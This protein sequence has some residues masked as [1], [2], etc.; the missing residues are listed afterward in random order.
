M[1]NSLIAWKIKLPAALC[2]ATYGFAQLCIPIFLHNPVR[3]KQKL[4]ITLPNIE[5][6]RKK[7]KKKHDVQVTRIEEGLQAEVKQY[8]DRPR[9]QG[10][11]Q[12]QVWFRNSM[13]KGSIYRKVDATSS[14]AV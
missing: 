13:P 14:G 12:N 3:E 10:L 4:H 8:T 5:E 6:N 2:E 9:P 7:R 11:Q 1:S